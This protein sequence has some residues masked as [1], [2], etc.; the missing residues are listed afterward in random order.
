MSSICVV[1]VPLKLAGAFSRQG[2]QNRSYNMYLRFK[3]SFAQFNTIATVEKKWKKIY[4]KWVFFVFSR[5]IRNMQ[6]I[7]MV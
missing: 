2:K 3:Y 4:R 6:I 5:L 7:Y 1:E